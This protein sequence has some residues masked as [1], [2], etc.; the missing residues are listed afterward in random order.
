MGRWYIRNRGDN[1]IQSFFH[2]YEIRLADVLLAVG[3]L[4][5]QTIDAI[6]LN[7]NGTVDFEFIGKSQGW[8][9][10]DCRKDDI[11]EQSDEFVSFVADLLQ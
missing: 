10:W 6:R 8:V 3:K 5:I 1:A 4:E 7:W 9:T 11:T 2:Y